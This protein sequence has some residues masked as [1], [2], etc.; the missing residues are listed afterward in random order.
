V[1]S[2]LP[3][4]V[5]PLGPYLLVPGTASLVYWYFVLPVVDRKDGRE[6]DQNGEGDMK[7]MTASKKHL[8]ASN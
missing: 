6:R 2:V 3:L 5:G 1:L 8:L 4:L 7:I